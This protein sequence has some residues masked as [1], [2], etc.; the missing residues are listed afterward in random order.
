MAEL[1]LEHV[2]KTYKG[3][4]EAVID[5]N[6]SVRDGEFL[7]LLGPSGCGKTSTLRMIV[8]LEE[9]TKGNIYI[10]ERVVNNLEPKDRNV[11][12]AFETYAL[13]PPL[14]IRENISFCLRAKNISSEK[15]ERKVND[16]ASML[17]IEDILDRKPGE[18]GGG[19]KQ[20]V[21][22]A[23]AL[24]RDPEVLLLDEPLS[25]LDA[26][27]R[28]HMRTELK[29]L[30]AEIRRTTILVT[31]DQLEAVAM[32]ERIAVMNFGVLQQVG[33]FDEVYL[34]PA[35]EFVAGFVG[36]PPMNFLICEPKSEGDDL[37]LIG[38]DGS[39]RLKLI[40]KLRMKVLEKKPK[41]IKLG[42]RPIHIEISKTPGQNGKLELPANVFTFEFLGEEGQVVAKVGQQEVLAMTPPSMRLTMNENICLQMHTE[43]TY[44]FDGE[45]GVSL[46]Y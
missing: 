16:V 9:I 33:T 38:L 12:L 19:Q 14:T 25:H 4:V 3:N 20:R 22:L 2:Y 18:I 44:L 28:A 1:R 8:G 17:G 6:L 34:N 11:A 24:V 27:Q 36:E 21:S 41:T 35:N 32:A 10:G 15:I 26:A 13:Y 42:I 40:P 43:F 31:H 46:L 29:R 39:F 7:A 30:H 23:R 45:T 37:F 5:L